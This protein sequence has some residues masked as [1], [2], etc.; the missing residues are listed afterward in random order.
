VYS[1]EFL[2][3]Y[4][5]DP[6]LRNSYT[7]F[8]GWVNN[9]ASS[10]EQMDRAFINDKSG[11]KAYIGSSR[12][13]ASTWD[14]PLTGFIHDFYLYQS[15]YGGGTDHYAANQGCYTAGDCWLTQFNNY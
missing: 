2:G 8:R 1:F 3:S 14:H 13:A 11:Y 10:Y 6:T 12:T 4:N 5:A 15:A 7:S 9:S